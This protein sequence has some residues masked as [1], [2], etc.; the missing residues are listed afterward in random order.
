MHEV[1][2]AH[3]G[4]R[5]AGTVVIVTLAL[6]APVSQAAMYPERPIRLVV[7]FNAGSNIDGT[8]RQVAPRISE[9]LGQQ[10]VIDNRGGASG[11]IGATLVAK[12]Q[13][14]GYTILMGNAP[15]HG[16]APN[17]YKK[18]P[19]DAVRDFSPIA[20]IA[21]SPYVLAVSAAVPV[22]S[23]KEL[24]A[25]AKGKPGQLNY[26]S[27]GNGT[28]VHLAGVFFNN[29]AGLDI[30]H[31]PY[32]NIGQMLGDISSG[33][34]TLIFYPYQPLTPV[35]QTGKVRLLA[36]TGA[37]R[38]SSLSTLPTMIESGIPGFDL[39]AWHGFYAPA[40]TPKPVVSVLYTA[41]RK[42]MSDS[43]L[44]ASLAASGADVD[45]ADPVEFAAFTRKQ[46]ER[47]RE[48]IQL[49]GARAD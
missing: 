25:Y 48:L 27:T 22:K 42:A 30:K 49:S 47:Y 45:L 29:K 38:T 32:N 26:A 36:T 13:P 28:G 18:L 40:G 35:I 43:K 20:R 14:D 7:P 6:I 31:V 3:A 17:L 44:V 12:S 1:R 11:T 33:T 9:H 16:I 23:V 34:I 21:T 4:A 19:Y 2:R 46:T 37:K 10:V 15:T 24:V 8:A 41:I 39:G 5:F